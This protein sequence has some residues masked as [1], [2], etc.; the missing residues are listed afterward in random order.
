MP[1]NSDRQSFVLFVVGTLIVGVVLALLI[2]NLVSIVRYQNLVHRAN[3]A[4]S[5]NVL[6]CYVNITL[7]GQSMWAVMYTSLNTTYQE[8]NASVGFS[9]TNTYVDCMKILGNPT[10]CYQWVDNT[11]QLYAQGG[12]D[13]RAI[14][15]ASTWLAFVSMVFLICFTSVLCYIDCPQQTDIKQYPRP[16]APPAPL[17]PPST[18]EPTYHEDDT[19]SINNSREVL[20]KGPVNMDA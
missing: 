3:T 6:W 15:I 18:P 7:N 1:R 17:A 16:I 13:S 5:C 20:P 19:V 14:A 9:T 4:T 12:G 8:N 10:T 2:W 11:M